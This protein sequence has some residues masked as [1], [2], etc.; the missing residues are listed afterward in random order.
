MFNRETTKGLLQY[1][2]KNYDSEYP[3]S[4]KEDNNNNWYFGPRDGD[5]WKI[6]PSEYLSSREDDNVI[7]RGFLGIGRKVE[8]VVIKYP[9]YTHRIEETITFF[10][11][12]KDFIST[13]SKEY[14]K[15]NWEYYSTYDFKNGFHRERISLSCGKELILT[16]SNHKSTT[17]FNA[18]MHQLLHD[19]PELNVENSKSVIRMIEGF[20]L[21]STYFKDVKMYN[22]IPLPSKKMMD[23]SKDYN[24]MC[25]CEKK[26]N[27]I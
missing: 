7:H 22:D 16:I 18:K 24:C 1:I 2:L 17:L 14:D 26:E 19:L 23:M 8:K 5:D 3:L 25:S 13:L 4:W 12:M 27:S 21:D 6:I 15:M 20:C 11:S 10:Q 9:D